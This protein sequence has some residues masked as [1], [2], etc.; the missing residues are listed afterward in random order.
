MRGGQ[1]EKAG[2]EL[3]GP[4]LGVMASMICEETARQEKLISPACLW[5]G[6]PLILIMV[7]RYRPVGPV[8]PLPPDPKVVVEPESPEPMLERD[9]D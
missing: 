2:S 3:S 7:D 8:A 1:T 4:L 5:N 6:N 9:P